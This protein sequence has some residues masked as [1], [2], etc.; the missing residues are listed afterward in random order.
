MALGVNH[1]TLEGGGV[2]YGTCCWNN[3]TSKRYKVSKRVYGKLKRE[4]GDLPKIDQEK[5][6]LYKN[7]PPPPTVSN[8]PSLVFRKWGLKKS[9][10]A[11]TKLI[12]STQ[13]ML[14][15]AMKHARQVSIWSRFV[16]IGFPLCA[17]HDISEWAPLHPKHAKTISYTQK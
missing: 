14:Q 3:C 8:W 6:L 11:E 13:C 2:G 17:R 12:F 15:F 7:H 10:P 16:A 5:K 9:L 4:K 1:L